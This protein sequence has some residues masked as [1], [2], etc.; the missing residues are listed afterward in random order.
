MHVSVC[1][2]EHGHMRGHTYVRPM[3]CN[4]Q[5]YPCKRMYKAAQS[6]IGMM[7][8][9]VHNS[10]PTTYPFNQ[11]NPRAV[12]AAQGGWLLTARALSW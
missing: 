1:V 9:A 2:W 3:L 5:L 10:T 8:H 11:S 12:K 4:V 7:W 6:E